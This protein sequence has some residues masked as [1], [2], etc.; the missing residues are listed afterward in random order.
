VIFALPQ[1][2]VTLKTEQI[3]PLKLPAFPE[4]SKV[5]CVFVAEFHDQPLKVTMSTNEIIFLTNFVRE[6]L[7]EHKSVLSNEEM[8]DGDDDDPLG[9]STDPRAY[10]CRTWKLDPL[11]RF[12]YKHTVLECPGVDSI[13][14]QL[15]FKHAKLT[16]P[17]W[18]QRGLL[19]GL[20]STHALFTAK[21]LDVYRKIK[22]PAKDQMQ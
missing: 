6:Y 10:M 19:D 4:E 9:N 22:N 18:F 20:D 14:K 5:S 13:I 21:L 15:G 2:E 1:T 11:T 12:M 17:K 16:I 7:R 3:Q 8:P